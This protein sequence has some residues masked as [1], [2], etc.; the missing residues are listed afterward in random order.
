MKRMC[1]LPYVVIAILVFLLVND[2]ITDS[3]DP[4]GK[5]ADSLTLTS[6]KTT[7][8]QKVRW[9]WRPKNSMRLTAMVQRQW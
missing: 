1:Q 8:G 7:G 4:N 3:Q 9:C 5:A 2:R 6:V